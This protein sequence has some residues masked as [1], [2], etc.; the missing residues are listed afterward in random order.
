MKSSTRSKTRRGIPDYELNVL[1]LAETEAMDL[2]EQGKVMEGYYCL[3]AGLERAREDAASSQPTGDEFL[4]QWQAA[5]D[6][7]CKRNVGPLIR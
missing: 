6:G 2:A 7:Y 3:I 5:V 1:M 4:R